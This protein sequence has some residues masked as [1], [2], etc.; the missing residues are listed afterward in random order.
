MN[1]AICI[2]TII[3]KK[4]FKFYVFSFCLLFLQSIHVWFLWGNFFKIVCPTVFVFA[5]LLN[6][7]RNKGLYTK[8]QYHHISGIIVIIALLAI[9][10]SY[11][12]GVLSIGKAIIDVIALYDVLLLSYYASQYLIQVLT[13]LF[14]II[15]IVSLIGWLLFL[16]G[17]P[18]PHEYIIDK[19]FGYAFE[20][21]YIFLYNT[22][23]LIPRFCSIY[24]EPGY[25]GQLAAIILFA[26]RMKIDN[27]YTIVILIG[28]LFSLSLAGYAL[29]AIGFIFTYLKR[30]YFFYLVFL[31]LIGFGFI[32][33]AKKYNGGDNAVNIWI[34][35][36]MEF[37]DGEMVG[38]NRSGE[39][40]DQ[41]MKTTFMQ[42]GNFLFGLGS[43]FEKMNWDH[44]VAGYKVYIAQK[45]YVGLLLAVLAYWLIVCRSPKPNRLMKLFFV[46]IMILYWQAAYPFWFCYFAVYVTGLGKLRLIRENV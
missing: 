28:V 7:S 31:L 11:D 25:Y 44:G 14:G 24:L 8:N 32:D 40:F 5:S 6:R 21:Y 42:N 1:N 10:G 33:G 43:K 45:G 41:Y 39:D 17:V 22:G 4:V 27:L 30:K 23:L 15:S 3:D 26:N 13:K 20:N 9:R 12:A 29:V 18:L 38:Y 19:E 2:E 34:L 35:S 46:L 16:F 36:R 37:E